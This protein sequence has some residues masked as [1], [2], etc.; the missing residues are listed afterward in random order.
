MNSPF[1]RSS[2]PPSNFCVMALLALPFKE[3]VQCT[4]VLERGISFRGN[5]SASL[6]PTLV[7]AWFTCTIVRWRSTIFSHR[8]GR[9]TPSLDQS[10]S[11]HQSLGSSRKLYLRRR[12]ALGFFRPKIGYLI[13]LVIVLHENQREDTFFQGCSE[14]FS[15]SVK[16][17]DLGSR[18]GQSTLSSQACAI[19]IVS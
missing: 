13:L 11:R 9:F 8:T 16:R 10:P 15:P 3:A 4:T 19:G 2:C 5:P 12:C 7:I 14:L 17:R 1:Q 18:L 6:E